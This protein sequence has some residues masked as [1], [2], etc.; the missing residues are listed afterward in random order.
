MHNGQDTPALRQAGHTGRMTRPQAHRTTRTTHAFSK[1]EV[2]TKA[3]Y[4]LT[5]LGRTERAQRANPWEVPTC[6]DASGDRVLGAGPHNCR[7]GRDK[8]TSGNRKVSQI[9]DRKPGPGVTGPLFLQGPHLLLNHGLQGQK[10]ADVGTM[11]L[12]KGIQ[13][14]GWKRE[15]SRMQT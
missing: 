7:Q 12:G 6:P 4:G 9:S 14:G 5:P 1:C 11:V 2:E 10:V 13:S 3:S 15:H 8:Q